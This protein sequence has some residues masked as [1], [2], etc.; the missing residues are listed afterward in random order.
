MRLR[1][2]GEEGRGE[3]N[4]GNRGEERHWDRKINDTIAI[5]PD[6]GSDTELLYIETHPLW[7]SILDDLK[8]NSPKSVMA[9][10]FHQG[11]AKAIVNM[12]NQLSPH[13]L[14]NRVVLTGGVF[15]NRI[16][17][18]EVSSRLAAQGI[19]VLTHS[20]VPPND[21]SLSLGQSAI[22]AATLISY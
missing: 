21:G 22:A 10:R 6:S 7:Q 13:N 15:Q 4:E 9:T 1:Q 8:E 19:T 20:L 3:R 2:M 5:S 12:V 18:E 16:L 17:L 14:S 11:L